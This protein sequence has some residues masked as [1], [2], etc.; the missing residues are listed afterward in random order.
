VYEYAPLGSLNVIIFVVDEKLWPFDKL[1]YHEV[2][3]GRP[4]SVNDTEYVTR[5]NVMFWLIFV[6]FTVM[7]PEDGD[8]EWPLIEFMLNEYVPL[9]SANEMVLVV[10]V[11]VVPFNVTDHDVPDGRPDSVNDT[12]YVTSVDV[13]V[14]LIALLSTMN[15]PCDEDGEYILSDDAMEYE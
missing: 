5:L 9:G 13:T 3:D 7:L 6:P 4:D 15:A 12:L 8:T 14:L 11:S 10:D 1:T 2:P